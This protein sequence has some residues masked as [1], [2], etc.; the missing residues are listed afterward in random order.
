MNR[1]QKVNIIMQAHMLFCPSISKDMLSKH[2][3]Y[4]RGQKN[5]I[6][7]VEQLPKERKIK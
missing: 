7:A 2:K 3:T 4:K 1:E 5:V 6:K